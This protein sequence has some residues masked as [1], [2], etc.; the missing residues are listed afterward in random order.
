MRYTEQRTKDFASNGKENP[1]LL[2]GTFPKPPARHRMCGPNTTRAWWLARPCGRFYAGGIAKAGNGVKG[3]I[4]ALRAPLTPLPTFAFWQ[5]RRQTRKA[6]LPALFLI[7]F[8]LTG[9]FLYLLD[10]QKRVHI[11]LDCLQFLTFFS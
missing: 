3:K 9:V 10:L 2:V 4:N 8:S 6:V 1:F 5:I 7:I 11:G